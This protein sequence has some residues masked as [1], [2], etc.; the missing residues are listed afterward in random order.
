MATTEGYCT[1]DLTDLYVELAKGGVGLTIAG[2]ASVMANGRSS[3]RMTG[4]HGDDFIPGLRKLTDAVHLH[5]SK[6]A[7]Q[8]NHGGRQTPGQ[9]IEG[10]PV[11]PSR[12]EASETGAET[13]ALSG[14]GIEELIDA[15][16]QT[17]RRARE[18]G[19]DAVQ[20]H[21]AHG[22]M[23]CQ[24]LS[25][26]T[27]RRTDQWGGAIENRMRFVLE[28]YKKC[29]EA[30]GDD[31]PVMIKLNCADFL[32]DGFTLDEG[33]QVAKALSDAGVDSIEVSGGVVGGGKGTLDVDNVPIRPH[34][35]IPEE[36]A[37]FLNES[38]EIR[39]HVSS[40]LMLVGGMRTPALME[41]LLE[42]GRGEFI[43]LCRPFLTEPDLADS[44]RNGRTEPLSCISC[45]LC[46]VRRTEPVLCHYINEREKKGKGN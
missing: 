4:L 32:D 29:R 24:F 45:N 38:E 25:P 22:Y 16:G 42:E 43:S 39:K 23:V 30:A 35:K 46:L 18:A 26:L 36:E 1:D 37:Y 6:I 41:R 10:A 27:N 34:I 9:F 3:I 21:G 19:Y 8:I 5:D 12:L 33:C 7:L 28:V 44:I 40:P 15:Y 31:Y 20:I 17:A 13:R 11:A 2:H 14:D